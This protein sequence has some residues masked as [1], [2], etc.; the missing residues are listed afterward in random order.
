[1]SNFYMDPNFRR[2][3]ERKSEPTSIWASLVAVAI[4]VGLFVVPGIFAGPNTQEATNTPMFETTG[5]GS[6]NTR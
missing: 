5:S 6:N 4:I 3:I 1:M 2:N